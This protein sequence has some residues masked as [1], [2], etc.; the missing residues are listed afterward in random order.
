MTVGRGQQLSAR[1][2][3]N[4]SCLP[5]RETLALGTWGFSRCLGG[6]DCPWKFLVQGGYPQ[7]LRAQGQLDRRPGVPRWGDFLG[8]E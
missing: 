1:G 5:F 4:A 3:D 6:C 2:V 8:A 7:R